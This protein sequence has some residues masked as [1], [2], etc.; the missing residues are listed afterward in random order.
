MNYY[1]YSM[2]LRV[3]ILHAAVHSRS[4]ALELAT[5]LAGTIHLGPDGTA[6]LR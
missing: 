2:F 4:S 5:V 3:H 6:M 1:V